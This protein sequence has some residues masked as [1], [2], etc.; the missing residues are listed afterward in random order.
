MA[1][2][3][4]YKE[5]KELQKLTIESGR[6]YIAGRADSCDIRLTDSAISRQ[7]L[8]I[9]EENGQWKA[10][11]TS[12]F[13][14]ISHLGA[15]HQTLDLED[16]IRFYTG[17]F[18]FRFEMESQSVVQ[19]AAKPAKK[20]KAAKAEPAAQP[21]AEDK[22]EIDISAEPSG[23]FP[24]PIG[25]SS[26]L[27]LESD[28]EEKTSL[29]FVNVQP[30]VRI[31]NSKSQRAVDTKLDGQY[32]K[33][34]RSPDCQ[35]VLDEVSAS[36]NHFE[37][38]KAGSEFTL[39]DLGSSN[40]TRLNGEILDELQPVPL[41]SGDVITIG[42]TTIEFQFRDPSFGIKLQ[43]VGVVPYGADYG[44][45]PQGQRVEVIRRKKGFK[46]KPI[47]M[48][49]G[50]ICLVIIISQLMGGGNSGQTGMGSEGDPVTNPESGPPGMS[51]QEE[52][53]LADS[54]KLAETLFKTQKYE[55]ALIEIRK[56]HEKVPQYKRSRELEAFAQQA[57]DIRN[58][59]AEEERRRQ[60]Q[61]RIRA[62]AQGIVEEC[63][64]RNFR[65]A[66]QAEACLQPATEMDPENAAAKALISKIRKEEEDRRARQANKAAYDA[67]VAELKGVFRRAEDQ[68][69]KGQLLNAIATY[70]QVTKSG[71]AD[72]GGLKAKAK[73]KVTELEGRIQNEISK[74]EQ[75][76]SEYFSQEKFKDALLELKKALELNPSS[77]KTKAQFDKVYKELNKRLKAIYGDS[78]LE[79]SL[80]NIEAAKQ[81]WNNILDMDLETGEYYQ[82]S[83]R[84]LKKYGG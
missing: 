24:A 6:E 50:A 45:V 19:K 55:A 69:R 13:G 9:F 76:A 67:E 54:Y 65:S 5:G 43:Q 46:A 57:I 16:G 23:N 21:K 1:I 53:L 25:G 30:Y 56:I 75:K 26:P 20:T 60:E 32:W 61:A 14:Q 39:T 70:T 68:E 73:A 63:R 48:A 15:L 41:R 22:S 17:D 36:R 81:K 44:I 72:P 47:H 84:Q 59:L 10:Q 7:H 2:L 82:K 78:V 49:I 62:E 66:D 42:A 38:K 11:I 37:I 27:K 71:N 8:R 34:G 51:K 12:R 83:K 58:D 80:G 35:I 64:A 74:S 4:V 33:A 18:E 52:K 29:G 40:G 79:E 28:S 3:R 77:V 31:F